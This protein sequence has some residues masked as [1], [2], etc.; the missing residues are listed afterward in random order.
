M[1]DNNKSKPFKR[2][3]HIAQYIGLFWLKTANFGGKIRQK[4]MDFNFNPLNAE[5]PTL[6]PTRFHSLFKKTILFSRRVFGLENN[7]TLANSGWRPRW[8]RVSTG[9]RREQKRSDTAEFIRK[10]KILSMLHF[11]DFLE[12]EIQ[13]F[14]IFRF[15][16]RYVSVFGNRQIS[17]LEKYINR[18]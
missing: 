16:L 9:P 8:G 10:K 4:L 2:V 12:A 17:S 7:P 18:S 11:W 1:P 5:A 13:F 6:P 15:S 3:L 14:M